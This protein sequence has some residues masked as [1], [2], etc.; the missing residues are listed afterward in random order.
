MKAEELAEADAAR[1][2]LKEAKIDSADNGDLIVSIVV[3]F[4]S[5]SSFFVYVVML[6]LRRLNSYSF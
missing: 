6:A 5:L 3:V 2:K 1:E 4:L